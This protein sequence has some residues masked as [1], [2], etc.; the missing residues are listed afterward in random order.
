MFYVIIY[1]KLFVLQEWD[2]NE[3]N[4]TLSRDR[5]HRARNPG[6]LVQAQRLEHLEESGVRHCFL[7]AQW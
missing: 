5:H 1:S 7:Q 4:L 2:K 3:F 6:S